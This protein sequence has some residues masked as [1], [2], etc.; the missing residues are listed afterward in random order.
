MNIIQVLDREFKIVGVLDDYISLIWTPRYDEMGEFELEL[1]IKYLGGELVKIDYAL[2]IPDLEGFMIIEDMHPTRDSEGNARLKLNGSSG[3]KLL[4]SRVFLEDFFAE[5]WAYWSIAKL[6]NDNIILPDNPRRRI[7]GFNVIATD[8]INQVEFEE[9]YQPNNVYEVVKAICQRCNYGFRV[10]IMADRNLKLHIYEGLDRSFNQ[11][12][13]PYVMFSQEF[14]NLLNEDYSVKTSDEHN[15]VYVHTG[16]PNDDG[17]NPELSLL[18]L[19]L[20]ED[21]PHGR[22]RKEFVYNA[23][24]LNLHDLTPGELVDIVG[25]RGGDALRDA[26]PEVIFDATSVPNVSFKFGEDFY[27]G[28]LVQ[29]VIFGQHI[30]ARIV[31][32][33]RTI[34]EHGRNDFVTFKM[35]DGDVSWRLPPPTFNSE[36]EGV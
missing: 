15:L 32:F 20:G 30:T 12:E 13:R 6:M 23:P 2:K 19:Y 9:W 10:D 5:G 31:E 17:G 35:D 24:D 21:E 34:D 28:D 27:L 7:D 8:V 4:K 14:D 11:S 36:S 33:A 18:Q 16:V 22:Y 26:K 3:S 1:P 25:T 29:C